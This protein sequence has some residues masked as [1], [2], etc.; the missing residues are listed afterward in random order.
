MAPWI[1]PALKA[2]LPHVG[3][4]VAATKPM[5]TKP[6]AGEADPAVEQQIAELQAAAAQNDANIR[7]LAG[8][9]Q[10]TVTA[11]ESAA[12]QAEDKTRRMTQLCWGAMGVSVLALAVAFTALFA[13]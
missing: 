11:L 10:K 4:I 3:T 9:L 12:A 13:S 7:E 1:I 2:V 8:Q 6:E 5:F